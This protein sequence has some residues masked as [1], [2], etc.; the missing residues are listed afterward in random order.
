MHEVPEEEMAEMKRVFCLQE[1]HDL[2]AKT[3]T[4]D[5]QSR[6][7][8]EQNQRAFWS[9][10]EKRVDFRERL[11]ASLSSRE[12]ASSRHSLSGR[13]SKCA[14]INKK[15]LCMKRRR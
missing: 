14:R 2:A 8:S 9:L 13:H 5:A 1:A 3:A 12:L 6:M 7:C 11:C 10:G 15:E 4:G